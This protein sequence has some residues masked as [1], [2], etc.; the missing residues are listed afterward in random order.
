V[1]FI[2]QSY[3]FIEKSEQGKDLAQILARLEKCDQE[4]FDCLV[5]TDVVN[6]PL[7]REQRSL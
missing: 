4:N 7:F 2:E 3:K 1:I 5:Q 6:V